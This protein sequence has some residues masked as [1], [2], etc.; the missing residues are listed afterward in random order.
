MSRPR[1]A[2]WLAISA[3]AIPLASDATPTAGSWRRNVVLGDNATDAFLLRN[4]WSQPGSYYC[5]NEKVSIV[6]VRLTDWSAQETW[7]LR[8]VAY[9]QDMKTFEWHI[10]DTDSSSVDLAEILRRFKVRPVFAEGWR[11]RFGI[12]STGVWVDHNRVVVAT[13]ADLRRHIPDLSSEPS[14]VR[15]DRTNGPATGQGYWYLTIRS[16]ACAGDVDWFEDVL[17]VPE[18]KVLD[19]WKVEPI[20]PRSK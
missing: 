8:Q 9:G 20:I 14:I 19:A 13:M 3:I 15:V 4:E 6:R 12:D 5:A 18:Q 11:E 17:M 16:G 10:T 1:L 7:V 2:L